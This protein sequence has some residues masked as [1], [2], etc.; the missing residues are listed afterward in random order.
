MLPGWSWTGGAVYVHS[1]IQIH[2]AFTCK[3]EPNAA[4]Q[5]KVTAWKPLLY[6]IWSNR[7]GM[8]LS[9]RALSSP[10]PKWSKSRHSKTTSSLPL[11]NFKAPGS[12][13]Q[14][15]WAMCLLES[16]ECIDFHFHSCFSVLVLRWR[17]K[18][19]GHPIT[20]D[21]S[22]ES[23]SRWKYVIHLCVLGAFWLLR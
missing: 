3:M 21:P 14:G 11:C 9:C 5:N 17:D 20:E 6:P 8:Q 2:S 12:W 23:T 18:E 16:V 19:P 10:H 15:S 13:K 22:N 4:L 1:K 7:L